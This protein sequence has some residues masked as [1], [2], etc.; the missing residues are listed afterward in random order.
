M[1]KLGKKCPYLGPCPFFK[2]LKL[3]ASADILKISYCKNHFETCARYQLK[4]TGKEVPKKLWPN[5]M[6]P[7]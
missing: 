7:N 5:G 1:T 2:S 4:F 6:E 3:P